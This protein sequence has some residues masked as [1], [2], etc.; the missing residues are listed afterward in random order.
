MFFIYLFVI[1]LLSINLVTV[2]EGN[3]GETVKKGY[4][5]SSKG[6][7]VLSLIITVIAMILHLD[8]WN[9]GKGVFYF[10]WIPQEFLYRTILIGVIVPL[11]SYIVTRISWPVPDEKENEDR[12]GKK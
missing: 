6:S 1:I 3:G 8:V 10:G 4:F 11:T 12:E 5:K 9:W 2:K 7:L